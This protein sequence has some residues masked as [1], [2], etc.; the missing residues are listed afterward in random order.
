M[1]ARGGYS[2][3]FPES[4][5]FANKFA[6]SASVPNVV[7]YCSLQLLKD[8]APICKSD[9]RLDNSTD[10]ATFYPEGQ[11]TYTVNG[12][13]IRGWFAVDFT[14]EELSNVS[15]KKNSCHS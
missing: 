3:L 10:I 1:I 12:E 11:K 9:L 15:G 6:I 5:D 4:S 13:S 14:Y 7:L 8:G 2:G